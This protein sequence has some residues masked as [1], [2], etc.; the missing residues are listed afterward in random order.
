MIG[1]HSHFAPSPLG[2]G[3][4]LEKNGALGGGGG[5]GVTKFVLRG[6]RGD[7]APPGAPLC[8]VVYIVV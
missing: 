8:V 1:G 2:G 6:K 4:G 7:G 5:G 3:G